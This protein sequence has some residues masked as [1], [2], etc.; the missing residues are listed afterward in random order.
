MEKTDRLLFLLDQLDETELKV[1]WVDALK[2]KMSDQ[3][4]DTLNKT[5]QV[6]RISAQWRSAHGHTL[7]NLTR[8]EHDL[9]WKQILIDVADKLKPGWGWTE[10]RLGDA[11]SEEE[12]EQLV[13]RYLDEKLRAHW[14]KFTEHEK[15]QVVDQLNAELSNNNLHVRGIAR[16][17]AARTV[18]VSS[19][20]SGI[21]AG[22][23][24]G[25]GAKMLAH[26]SVAM[27]FGALSGGTMHQLGVW[28][29]V[30]LL[31][32]WSGAKL[33]I[34]GAASTIGGVLL[35]TPVAVA[36]VANFA[37]SPSYGKSIPATLFL[38]LAHEMRR[39]LD[40]TLDETD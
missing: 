32:Y 29:A 1:I 30:R 38:L 21:S 20:T 11:T 19:L 6:R 2:C 10:Y 24:T 4:F 18:T 9:P 26:G 5:E 39:Q 31:G 13:L 37:M 8:K 34:G 3:N 14:D 35:S 25:A 28:L 15:L 22:L 12:L 17:A 16:L 40:S 27:V 33:A 7:I 36:M 23:I